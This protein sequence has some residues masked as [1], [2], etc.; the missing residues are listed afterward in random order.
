MFAR[1]EHVQNKMRTDLMFVQIIMLKSD[2]NGMF[3]HSY[4]L[5]Q[6][7]TS[8]IRILTQYLMHFLNVLVHNGFDR[9][10]SFQAVTILEI[11]TT[12]F[13][14]LMWSWPHN[15]WRSNMFSCWWIRT[16]QD[17]NRPYICSNYYVKKLIWMECLNTLTSCDNILQALIWILT[18]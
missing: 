11:I 13:I 14:I 2:V 12:G 17:E 3:K 15:S 4:I 18:Q 7:S 16:K 9:L 5:W 10:K 1:G 8:L 6:H